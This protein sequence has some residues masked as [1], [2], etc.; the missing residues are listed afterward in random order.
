MKIASKITGIV[1]LS[2]VHRN[3][4]RASTLFSPKLDETVT[5]VLW[6]LM[7]LARNNLSEQTE[8]LFQLDLIDDR[9]QLADVKRTP[10]VK[11]GFSVTERFFAVLLVTC[12]L[13]VGSRVDSTS[14]HV[15]VSVIV[16]VIVSSVVQGGF[17]KYV[18]MAENG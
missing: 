5:F 6:L 12:L 7:N 11:L 9:M 3:L 16:V 2:H 15:V 14:V 13:L 10:A 17:A 1:Q 4:R 18:E 8:T